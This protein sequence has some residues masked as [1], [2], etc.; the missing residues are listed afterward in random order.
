MIKIIC[1]HCAGIFT[2]TDV[3]KSYDVESNSIICPH[4]D[5]ALDLDELKFTSD[6]IRLHDGW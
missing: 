3:V 5:S 6:V 1:R 4:C 2:D